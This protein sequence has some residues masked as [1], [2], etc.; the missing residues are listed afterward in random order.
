M[1]TILDQFQLNG[2]TALIFGGN[3]GLGL[4]IAKALAEAGANIWIASRNEERNH[5]ACELIE[6]FFEVACSAT[7]CD[8]Q[9]NTEIEEVVSQVQKERGRID[10]LV[11]SA[12]INVRGDIESVTHE[13]FQKVMDVNVTGSWSTCKAVVPIMKEQQYGRIL[14][15]GSI[16]SITA[17]ANRTPYAT[18]K[19]A[20]IQLTRALAMEL[21]TEKITVN[22]LL[23]GP[24][25]T[26]MNL[27]LTNDPE[28]FAAFMSRIP[29]GRWG[30][31]DEIG[32]LALYLCSPSSSFVTGANF[33]IDGGWTAI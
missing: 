31:L 33:V 10:I 1:G 23:P 26:E 32:G 9:V 16:L 21:A 24:F 11:N 15:I 8:V 17:I 7:C 12:G 28:Q 13:D 4:E 22:S 5:L 30:Q 2:Q 19:G 18:S 14:N 25:A 20:V 29:M 27:P 6:S 3:R